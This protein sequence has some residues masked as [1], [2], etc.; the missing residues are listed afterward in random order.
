MRIIFTV[1]ALGS[2]A[3]ATSACSGGGSGPGDVAGCSKV[4]PAGFPTTTMGTAVGDTAP[5]FKLHDKNGVDHCV[6]DFTGKVVLI[7]VAAGWCGPCKQEMPSIEAV[8]E[9]Y[10][11]QGF[12]VVQAMIDGFQYPSTPTEQ[13]L[14]QWVQNYHLQFTVLADPSGLV[15]GQYNTQ[16]AIPISVI[17]DRDHVIRVQQVGSFQN[18]SQIAAYVSTYVNQAPAL[19]YDAP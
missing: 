12:E 16:D 19:N 8:Y 17:L 6:R 7:N 3:L 2:L 1:L 11:D 10:R 4:Q 13:F 9:Q 18:Q 15:F 14:Q 5:D